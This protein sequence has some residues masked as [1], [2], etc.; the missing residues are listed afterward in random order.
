MDVTTFT[1]QR[2]RIATAAGEVAYTEFGAGPAAVFV[3]G[4]GT[5]GLLWRHVI[6]RL[7]D[8]SR[9][10]AVDLPLHGGTP[11]REDPSVTA[12][13]EVL[14]ELC[15]GLG[16]DQ[17]DLVG[18]DTGGAVTQV[19]AA[20]HPERLRTLTLTNCDTED[21]FPPPGF[22]PVIEMAARGELAP[23]LA[24][25]ARDPA[26]ARASAFSA[27]FEHPDRITDEEF[28]DY[29]TPIVGTMDNARH[30]ERMLAALGSADDLKQVAEQLRGLE[31]PTLLVWGT[32]DE[33]FGVE[34]AYRL[35]DTI[36]GA[37][38][39]VEVDGAKLFFPA[40]RP[41]DLVVALREH[42]Q[43]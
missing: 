31:V 40:E 1:S 6:D 32:G 30:F 13:S 29:L 19:F 7:R 17:I 34:W 3:H 22:L 24:R 33:A 28:R 8:T 41:D 43:R 36:P 37:R 38:D 4:L 16:L 15:A 27:G 10:I 5:N 14:T 2:R 39:V 26:A 12:M 25:L 23:M 9:C 18:N 42:W 20:R 21:N 35:R 11:A